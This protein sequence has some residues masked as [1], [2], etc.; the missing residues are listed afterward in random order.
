[1][2]SRSPVAVYL[3]QFDSLASEQVA[4]CC[5]V[6]TKAYD[7]GQVFDRRPSEWVFSALLKADT[8]TEVKDATFAFAKSWAQSLVKQ[9]RTNLSIDSVIY[10]LK[11]LDR[12]EDKAAVRKLL[13]YQ[14]VARSSRVA[15][16]SIELGYFAEAEKQFETIWSGNLSRSY[17]SG[18]FTKELESKLPAFLERFNNEGEK[19]FAN[20]YLSSL[21]NAKNNTKLKTTP[22]SRLQ[23]LAEQFNG[24]DF[25][26]KRRRQTTLILLSRSH[27]KAKAFDQA[28]TQEAEGMLL[29]PLFADDSLDLPV[30][31]LGSYLATQIG[32]ENFKSV[33]AKWTQINDILA[34]RHSG[35]LPYY[36]RRNLEEVAEIANESFYHLLRA[37]TPEQI[38][39]I[40]PKLRDLN[41]PAY[42]RPLNPNLTQAVYLMSGSSNELAEFRKEQDA[43]QNA[44]SK[45]EKSTPSM[46]SF[47]YDLGKHFKKIKTTNADVEKNFITNAWRFGSEQGFSFGSKSFKAGTEDP[48]RKKRTKYGLE[49]VQS[50]GFLSKKKLLKFGSELAGINSVNGEIWL[51][52]ARMQAKAKKD[53]KAAESFKNSI[54]EAKED[55]KKAK[56]N[57]R[58][59]YANTLL[60]LKRSDEAKE[61]I[62]DIPAKELFKGNKKTL[63]KLQDKLK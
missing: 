9:G 63:K 50:Q 17:N 16:V 8:T 35:K 28:L 1:M 13:N 32:L 62:K 49:R 15:V 44:N 61:M 12:N 31:L 19:Y 29:E 25:K 55:M 6:I 51:Q 48:S 2:Q 40:L 45:T 5:N 53:S 18:E 56:F 41:Q 59:E 26:S 38:A 46:N 27:A 34:K 30:E 54:E 47:L 3:L 58:V 22:D 21:P 33:E 52:L 20:V 43:R 42:R 37:K 7:A 14:Y 57:R 60:K 11:I 24:D 39:E 23:S 10:C 36:A 4:S